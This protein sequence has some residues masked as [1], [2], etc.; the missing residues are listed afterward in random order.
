M[1]ID[2]QG[3][4]Q[5]G[6]SPLSPMDVEGSRGQDG[7]GV[8]LPE[9]GASNPGPTDNLRG[10][11]PNTSIDAPSQFGEPEIYQTFGSEVPRGEVWHAPQD[12]LGDVDGD[13]PDG[14]QVA[15]RT[16]HDVVPDWP[17]VGSFTKF[18]EHYPANGDQDGDGDSGADTDHDG[19]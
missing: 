4:R 13:A 9:T 18:G 7:Y 8:N 17:Q 19:M 12:Q 5:V 16:A 11:E 1:A 3:A 2:M 15:Q 14:W 10:I 6:V